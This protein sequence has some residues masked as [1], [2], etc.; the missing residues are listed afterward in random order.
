MNNHITSWW[1]PFLSMCWW[2]E[3]FVYPYGLCLQGELWGWVLKSAFAESGAT[4]SVAFAWRETPLNWRHQCWEWCLGRFTW[5]ISL[6]G[7][8]ACSNWALSDC[9]WLIQFS[10]GTWRV[11]QAAAGTHLSPCWGTWPWP[12][13]STNPQYTLLNCFQW[14]AFCWVAIIRAAVGLSVQCPFSP[15]CNS[16]LDACMCC[17]GWWCE[18]GSPALPPAPTGSLPLLLLISGVIAHVSGCVSWSSPSL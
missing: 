9:W 4:L 3:I 11:P 17:L 18:H 13:P 8:W 14:A 12:R 6:Y 15:V 1:S 7:L 10:R 5:D 2:R 16:A